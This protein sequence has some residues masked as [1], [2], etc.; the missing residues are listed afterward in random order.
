MG[1]L[2]YPGC[3]DVRLNFEEAFLLHIANGDFKGHMR[4]AAKDN[5]VFGS[6]I[7][8]SKKPYPTCASAHSFDFTTTDDYHT[9]ILT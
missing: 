4:P 7:L 5:A 8:Y 1:F 9:P 3:L 2:V 6:D